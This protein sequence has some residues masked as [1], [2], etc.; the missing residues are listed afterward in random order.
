MDLVEALNAA[1][2]D[3][4]SNHESE[5]ST[6]FELVVD[7]CDIEVENEDTKETNEEIDTENVETIEANIL[8]DEETEDKE[9]DEEVNVS[10]EQIEEL[11]KLIEEQKTKNENVASQIE[12]LDENYLKLEDQIEDISSRQKKSQLLAIMQQSRSAI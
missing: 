2:T 9:N 7:E 10:S 12:L 4:E 11:E 5:S 1:K 3:E 8:D 6:F